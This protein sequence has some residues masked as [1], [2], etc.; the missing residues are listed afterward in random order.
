MKAEIR[1]VPL[2]NPRDPYGPP[3]VRYI[4]KAYRQ[5]RPVYVA[6][7]TRSGYTFTLDPLHARTFSERAARKHATALSN[8]AW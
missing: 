5:P 2:N 1:P 8:L 4:V 3:L 6:H 7:V